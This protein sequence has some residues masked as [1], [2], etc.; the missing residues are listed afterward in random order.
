MH[1][2]NLTKIYFKLLTLFHLIE[3]FKFYIYSI[4][5]FLFQ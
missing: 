2:L 3:L 1:Y 4:K 5:V